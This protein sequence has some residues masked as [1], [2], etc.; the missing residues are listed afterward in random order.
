MAV[1]E[2]P[3]PASLDALESALLSVDRTA[4]TEAL[5]PL[6]TKGTPH[7]ERI[8]VPVLDRIGRA[9]ERGEASLAQVYM[10]GRLCDELVGQFLPA[11]RPEIQSHP[12]VAIVVLEDFH[13][14]GARMVSS[15]VRASGYSLL[16]YGRMQVD[17]LV[18][19]V[20]ADRVAV[21]LVSVLMLPSALGVGE[22]IRRLRARGCRTRVA[23]GGAPFRLDPRL[24]REVGADGCGVSAADAVSLT[25]RLLQEDP[26]D[27]E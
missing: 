20:V 13:V 3:Q 12:P 22:F 17:E 26:W 8:I 6:A 1:C 11:P 2:D 18:D 7:L 10:A 23:V 27:S 4:A 24:A 19:R 9:W 25:R 14:L 16:D 5:A 21:L 15:V